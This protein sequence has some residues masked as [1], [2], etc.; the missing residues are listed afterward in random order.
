ME[1]TKN[2]LFVYRPVIFCEFSDSCI[3]KHLHYISVPFVIQL[4]LACQSAAAVT[5][6]AHGSC[7]LV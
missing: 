7:L 3:C 4:H 5:L 2:L 6:L 1:H